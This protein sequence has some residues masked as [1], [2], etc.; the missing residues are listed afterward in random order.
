MNSIA[1]LSPLPDPADLTAGQTPEPLLTVTEA[2]SVMGLKHWQIRRAIKRGELPAY[3]A[4]SQRWRVR[5]SD[6]EAVIQASRFSV[7]EDSGPR[8]S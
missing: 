8:G 7:E 2:A 4:F 3:A 6:I 5:L 1:R